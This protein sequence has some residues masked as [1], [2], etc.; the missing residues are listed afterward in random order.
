M[1]WANNQLFITKIGINYTNIIH[2]YYILWMKRV[3][4][5]KYTQSVI[6]HI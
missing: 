2:R 6:N 1:R 5:N 4:G 3:S